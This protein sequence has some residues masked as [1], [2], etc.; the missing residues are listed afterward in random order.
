MRVALYL[1]VSTKDQTTDNQLPTLHKY[2]AD[3]GWNI[4]TTIQDIESG[5][6]CTRKGRTD[7][8]NMAQAGLFDVVV[9]WKLDRWSRSMLDTQTTTHQLTKMGVQFVSVTEQL[10]T[11][12]ASGELLFN[13]LASVATFERSIMQ[14]RIKAGLARRK[15]QGFSLGAPIKTPKVVSDDI[16]S[17]KN[18]GQSVRTIAK[19]L[20]MSRGAVE[21][22]LNRHQRSLYAT[23]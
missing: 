5:A 12:S 10:D 17:R 4:V 16:V 19:T 1:R 21:C 13:V 8:M 18:Q 11:K 9:V 20:K 3:R 14:E 15:L 23:N 2:C 6:S 22:A 7:L